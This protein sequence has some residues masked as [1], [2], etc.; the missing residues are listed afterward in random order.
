MLFCYLH[1]LVSHPT[2]LITHVKDHVKC[3]K[4]AKRW[5]QGQR[6]VEIAQQLQGPMCTRIWCMCVFPHVVLLPSFLGLSPNHPHHTCTRPCTMPLKI[7]KKGAR[8]MTSGNWPTAPRPHVHK[9]RVYVCL[10]KCCSVTFIPWSLPQPPSSH[11][12]KTMYNAWKESKDGGKA[13]D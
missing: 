10:S 11:M 7:Q 2:T 5:G 13:N 3:L 8:P 6:L 12:Y 1:S 4:R 9:N